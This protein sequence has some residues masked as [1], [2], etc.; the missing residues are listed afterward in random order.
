MTEKLPVS[1]LVASCNEGHLLEDCLKSLQFCDEIYFVNIGST[2]NSVE[3]A[4]KY[5]TVIE[6]FH[7]VPRIEDVHPI[8]IPKLK[9]DWF[10]LIDPDERIRPELAEDIKKYIQNPE[11]FKSLIR[12][13]LWYYFKGKKLKGGPY[14][15][16]V[17]GRL[18]FYRPGINISDEVHTGITAKPGYGIAEIPFTGLNYDE[19][20]WCNSWEQLKDKHTR[21]AKGE[22]KVLYQEGKRFSWVKLIYKTIQAFLIAFIKQE[23]YRDGFTGLK[24]SYHEGRYSYISW[25]SLRKYQAELKKEGKLLTPKQVAM[26]QMQ[27]K[28]QQFVIETERIALS[29]KQTE[30]TSLKAQII[31]QYQKS[32]HRLVNDA[33]EINAFDLA[34][35][36]IEAASFNDEMKT[37]VVTDILMGRLKLIQ[38]SGSYRLVKRLN[39]K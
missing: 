16:A 38:Y 31:K 6:E 26:E 29:Y 19:H 12:A 37:F 35:I 39:G 15:N 10:I 24:F 36:A 18:L 27:Q 30:D 9:H 8:Y 11:P 4:Q 1:V 34:Q 25:M 2:D 21:Y 23:Y 22:G 3:I 7:K 17:R 28:V 20:Y 5:A 13:Y 33:L 32:L 14:K